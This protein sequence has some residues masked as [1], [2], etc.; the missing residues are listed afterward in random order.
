MTT[1]NGKVVEIIVRD[2]CPYLDDYE[3]SYCNPAAAAAAAVTLATD[4]SVTWDPDGPTYD[5][6]KPSQKARVRPAGRCPNS[7]DPDSDANSDDEY[8]YSSEAS[9]AVTAQVSSLDR[10]VGLAPPS[11]GG[12]S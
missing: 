10:R 5:E 11:P 12:E 3:P 6:P 4:K 8:P 2:C 7:E 1:A 9:P